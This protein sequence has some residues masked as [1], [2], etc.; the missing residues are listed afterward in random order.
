M[1]RAL[2]FFGLAWL[3]GC[4]GDD[5]SSSGGGGGSDAGTEAAADTG[6]PDTAT[7]DT[8]TPDTGTPDAEPDTGP[9]DAAGEDAPPPPACTTDQSLCVDHVTR[10]FCDGGQWQQETCSP[11]S[12]CVNG[13]CVSGAC[14]DA[15]RLGE[16]QGGQTCELYDVASD[17]WV[18]VDPEGALHDRARAYTQ[19]LHRDGVAFGGVGNARYT[20]PPDYTTVEHLGGLGD[21]AIWTGTYLAA[22]A[23]RLKATGAADARRN[24]VDLVNTL[25]LWFNVSGDPG[26]LARFVAPSNEPHPAALGDLDCSAERCHCGVTYEGTQYDYIGHISRDQ[27][28]GVMLGYAL[29]YEALGEKE[30][31]TRELI[32]QDVVEL[33]QELMKERTVPTKVT[34]NGTGVGPFDITM[35]FTVLNSAE[36]DN[37]AVNLIVDTNNYDDSEMYGFQEFMPNLALILKQVPVLSALVPNTVPRAGS[38]VMLASFFNVAFMVTDGVDAYE[39]QRSEMEAFYEGNTEFGGNINDWIPIMSGWSYSNNC[40]SSYYANNIV[41]EPMY[42]LARL[43]IDPGRRGIIRSNVLQARM[44]EEFD[45]TKNSFFAFIY[46]A[47]MPGS[48][49]SVHE[50]AET[51]LAQFPPPPRV[52]VAVDLTTD[53]KYLPHQDGCENQTDHGG[54]VD[55]GERVVSDFIWQ[56]HPWG[57]LDNGNPAQTYPGIDYLVAYWMGRQH[58]YID[59]DTAGRCTAWR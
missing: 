17:S 26:M 33:V 56:R 57:L 19:W 59:D 32:R 6:T 38:G 5:S 20:D 44:W 29:A 58:G 50:E 48:A 12:G 49:A 42:N 27:Y 41:M 40:G 54:A 30:E 36:M 8:G 3:A 4:G 16:T 25:H 46:S 9:Q 31:D 11:G 23:L 24:V 52:K 10:M 39:T 13:A 28:Q 34:F 47:C 15:C 7:P 18:A 43:E 53:P 51:Q 21:S 35:R 45:T 14:S 37:G 1:K 55:V 2:V 22:E